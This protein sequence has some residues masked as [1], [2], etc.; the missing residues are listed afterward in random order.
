MAGKKAFISTPII[1]DQNW[2]SAGSSNLSIAHDHEVGRGAQGH[3]VEAVLTLSS[4]DSDYSCV[5]KYQDS[6]EEVPQTPLEFKL[7]QKLTHHSHAGLLGL[8]GI[9]TGTDN[10]GKMRKY[11]VLPKCDVILS[12]CMP[13]IEQLQK[14]DVHFFNQ[15][16]ID[17]F[18]SMVEGLSELAGQQIVHQDLK[19]KNI[20]R[21]KNAWQI[22]DFGLAESYEDFNK[23]NP[24]IKGTPYYIAPELLTNEKN[25]PFA[26]DVWAVGLILRR[27]VSREP[28]LQYDSR[29]VVEA[30]LYAKYQAFEVARC[31]NLNVVCEL[32]NYQQSVRDVIAQQTTVED[33]LSYITDIMCNILPEYRPDLETIQCAD[34]HLQ[35]LLLMPLDVERLSAFYDDVID[36]RRPKGTPTIDNEMFKRL[37]NIPSDS[38]SDFTRSRSCFFN[39]SSKTMTGELL[40]KVP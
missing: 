36:S 22:F 19:P 9:Y 27:L 8:I 31:G 33:C 18:H 13:A 26:G 14:E 32:L 29:D 21:R 11:A 10:Q 17:F 5:A 34:K 23:K 25:F 15:V 39:S 30:H 28:F 40:F 16:L 2:S 37:E 20:G 24:A 6:E 4:D 38:P 7:H 3:V 12:D 1:P 35:S